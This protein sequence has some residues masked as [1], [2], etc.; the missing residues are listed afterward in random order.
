MKN[1][2]IALF[3]FIS[4]FSCKKQESFTQSV[5]AS[6]N[7]N[8]TAATTIQFSGYTWNIK[9]GANLGP[10]PNYWSRK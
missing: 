7:S 9:Y 6:S 3:S 8:S 2:Y 5:P 1:I 10:G 4:F